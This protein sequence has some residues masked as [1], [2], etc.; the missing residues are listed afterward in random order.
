M[1]HKEA[2]SPSDWSGSSRRLIESHQRFAEVE[3]NVQ[4][5]GP[6][7]VIA[8]LPGGLLFP[9]ICWGHFSTWANVL[10]NGTLPGNKTLLQSTEHRFDT[11]FEGKEKK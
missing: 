7:A 5:H 2:I 11:E 10:R 8:Q 3:V 9:P 6:V 4:P 1:Q